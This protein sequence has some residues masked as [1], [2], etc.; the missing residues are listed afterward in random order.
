LL[1]AG[2]ADIAITQDLD[3]SGKDTLSV[4]EMMELL[5]RLRGEARINASPNAWKLSTFISVTGRSDPQI[6]YFQCILFLWTHFLAGKLKFSRDPKSRRIQGPL[7]RYFV[8]VTAP[9][10]KDAAPSLQSLP[11]IVRRQ[12]L[13]EKDFAKNMAVMMRDGAIGKVEVKSN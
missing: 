1:W 12:A 13:F 10:M 2:K 9:V 5:T 6:I 8:A 11:D 4:A 3:L 7:V